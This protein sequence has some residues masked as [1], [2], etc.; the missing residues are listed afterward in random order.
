MFCLY[1][2]TKIR[3]WALIDH[4]VSQTI[5][6]INHV[7]VRLKDSIASANIT[8]V[9]ARVNH[10]RYMAKMSIWEV[11]LAQLVGGVDVYTQ[12]PSSRDRKSVV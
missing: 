7:R 8:N 1:S 11:S 6:R 10:V 3:Y 9:S 12:H 5:C 2:V 4:H